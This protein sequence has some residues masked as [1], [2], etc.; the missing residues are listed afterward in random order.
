VNAQDEQQH[1]QQG[2]VDE[3]MNQIQIQGQKRYGETI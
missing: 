3:V 2:I 1:R